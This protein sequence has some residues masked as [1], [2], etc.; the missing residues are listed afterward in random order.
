V[1]KVFVVE[2]S[3][4]L[5][6]RLLER[7]NAIPDLTVVGVAR[8]LMD[9]VRQITTKAPDVV[10]TDP[11]LA[12]GGGLGLLHMLHQRREVKGSG[13]RVLLWTGDRDPRRWAVAMGLGAEARYDKAREVD[14]LVEHCRRAASENG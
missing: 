6:D 11:E 8:N 1:V 7:L 13:P 9:A 2:E 4:G 5:S 14:L 3:P 10:I 12:D